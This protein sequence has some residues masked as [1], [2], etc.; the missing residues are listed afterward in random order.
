MR[1]LKKTT[2]ALLGFLVLFLNLGPSL[3]RAQFEMAQEDGT[4]ETVSLCSCA[5]HQAM[6]NEAGSSSLIGDEDCQFCQF[7]AQYNVTLVAFEATGAVSLN[8]VWLQ[9]QILPVEVASLV[10][11]AR[12]PP[13]F[14]L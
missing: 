11:T 5:F 9:A 3:H 1:H 4:H 8:P 10:A 6:T 12:G 13:E 14:F 2:Y 7:F